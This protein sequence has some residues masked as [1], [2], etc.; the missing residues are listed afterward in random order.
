MK[1]LY[2]TKK[3]LH[4][5]CNKIDLDLFCCTLHAT[6]PLIISL[7]KTKYFHGSIMKFFQALRWS[8][9]YSTCMK[10]IR[11]G[12][13]ALW[14]EM[15]KNKPKLIWIRFQVFIILKSLRCPSINLNTLIKYKQSF[16]VMYMLHEFVFTIFNRL[17]GVKIVSYSSK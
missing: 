16:C 10:K 8:I 17:F 14:L 9:L 4:A 2:L 12:A 13:L 11:R 6:I 3:I 5:T 7:H 15:K 1:A